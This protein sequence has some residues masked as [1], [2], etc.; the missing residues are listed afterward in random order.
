MEEEPRE[1]LLPLR[2]E[3]EDP[4]TRVEEEE[5]MLLPLLEEEDEPLRVVCEEVVEE[6]LPRVVP[7]LFRV[8]A[9]ASGA[10]MRAS[11]IMRLAAVV[12]KR[13]ITRKV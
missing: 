6:P 9:K 3:E 12:I 8:C 7:E 4:L 5:E 13:L 1:V 11:A 10:T 2:A